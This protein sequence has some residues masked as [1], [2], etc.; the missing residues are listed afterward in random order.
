MLFWAVL[1]DTVVHKV[2][3]SQWHLHS[4]LCVIVHMYGKNKIK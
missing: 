3:H 2:S 1:Q 4:A